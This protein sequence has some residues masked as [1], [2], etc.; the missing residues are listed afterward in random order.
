MREFPELATA[1][2]E[3]GQDDRWTDWSREAIT[4]RRDRTRRSLAALESIDRTRLSPADRLNEKLYEQ[5]L[6]LE[7]EGQRFPDEWLPVNQ[8][9]GIQ[10]DLAETVALMPSRTTADHEQILARLRAV[11]TLV[12][13]VVTLM[14]AGA[15]RRITPPRV[16]LLDVPAQIEQLMAANSPLLRPFWASPGPA[17]PQQT[18]RVRREAE[19][20]FRERV[21]PALARLRDFLLREYIPAARGSI[22]LEDLP[23]GEAWYRH[24]V[25][26]HTTTD[27]TPC[28]I[29]DIGLSEVRRI[30][31]EMESTLAGV[32]FQGSL[33]EF[34]E[35]LRTDPRFFFKTPSGLLMAYRDIAKRADEK[36]VSFF[37]RL[38]RLPY[39]V[40]AVPA[41]A[42]KSQTTAYYQPGSPEA[43]RPGIFYANTYD[44]KSRPRWEMEALTLHE[45]VPGHHLQIALAQE[46]AE[47]PD[48]R[49]HASIT[50]FVEGWGLYAESLGREMGFYADSYSRFGQL[51]YEMWRAIRLVVDTGM[52]ALGWT[53]QKAIDYFE[54]NTGK[55]G[56]DIVVEVDRYL[57]W[58]GQALAYT[59]GEL[60]IKD[61]RARAEEALGE[62]F[63]L[64]A[65]HDEILGEGPLPLDILEEQMD[66]WMKTASST[67]AGTAGS[68]GS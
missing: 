43:A 64:R 40:R 4:R 44:L 31:G 63:D 42:E 62:R 11:P 58:P 16:T 6:R 67:R 46:K 24:Q 41:Y 12:S 54:E 29:H 56:H 26:L 66:R 22:A 39:G 38:P 37:G 32:D 36:L 61:L 2:G 23:D 50:A 53:R 30:R 60:R 48:F 5:Q 9:S 45:A 55:A 18:D 34:F 13:Q 27:L 10:H 14:E 52:H 57:A 25:R 51:I 21:R 47:L 49:R 28:Q 20:V 35:F 68:P 65:F 7:M 1:V 15:K 59:I 17:S 33:A 3:P 8:M 19:S